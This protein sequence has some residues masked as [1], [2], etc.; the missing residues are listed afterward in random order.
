[1][2]DAD[3]LA[4]LHRTVDAVVDAFA[5]N[6]NWGSSGARDDQYHSD[7]I[8]DRAALAVLIDAGLRVLS[9][10]SGLGP[11]DGPVAVLDPLDG[12]TNASRS[13]PWFATS[14]CVVDDDGPRASVVHDHPSGMR[15]DAVRGDGARR[16]GRLLA[17]RGEI[18]LADAIVVVNGLPDRHP[19]WAQYRCM[20]AAALDLCAVADGRFDAYVDYD[21]D[22]HGPWDYLGGLLVCREV[23]IE[24]ADAFGRDLVVV[25]H[26]ARRTPVAAPAGLLPEL[27][28]A[29]SEPG[30]GGP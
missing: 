19:G 15:F 13:L 27:L 5:T 12:S 21:H 18:A 20:G 2:D 9:E 11:G 14:V 8:S 30:R 7:V 17:P 6:H 28:A 10:E 4:V 3:L 22:G 23:G 24:V 25:D 29:R 26:D 1:M 16:D